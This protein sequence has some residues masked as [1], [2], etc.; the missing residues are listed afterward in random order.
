VF[1]REDAEPPQRVDVS[2]STGTV[3]FHRITPASYTA[4]ERKAFAGR[5]HSDE[6]GVDYQVRVEDASLQLVPGDRGPL[7]LSAGAPDE[8]RL[9]GGYV[10]FTRAADGSVDGFIYNTRRVARLRFDRAR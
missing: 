1:H 6:L 9:R 2:R 8:F 5:Y 7:P 4:A 10:R 3:S